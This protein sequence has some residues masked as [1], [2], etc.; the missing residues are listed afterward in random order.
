M[1]LRQD[2]TALKRD[3]N[4]FAPPSFTAGEVL[5]PVSSRFYRFCKRTFDI[6]IA[7]TL[8]VGLLP[9][10][11]MVAG[12]IRA[13]G[14]SPLFSHS[15]VGKHGCTF[16]CYKFRTMV[17]DADRVLS[18]YLANNL[19]AQAE[20]SR[21][22]KLR[23]DPRVTALGRFLRR[24]SLDELPQL[25]N[26][27]KGEMTLVGP[28]PVVHEELERYG[29]VLR[30]YLSVRPGVTGIWQVSGR[31]DTSYDERVALDAW[32]VENRSLLLDFKIL[33][34]T[35]TVPFGGRGAY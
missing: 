27:L 8:L 18:A 26:V 25:I 20:W 28:R 10:M 6:T 24:T 5:A 34:R 23:N 4:T 29:D 15:R 9:F 22:H 21:D 13:G 2:S 35:L 16:Q 12:A 17:M 32:Y 31:N 19:E 30:A 11:L 33:L 14:A 3:L 7:G 1:P